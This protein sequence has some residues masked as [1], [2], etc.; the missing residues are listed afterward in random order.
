MVE[1]EAWQLGVVLEGGGSLPGPGRLGDPQLDGMDLLG[2]GRVLLGMRDP[3]ARRHEVQLAG[4]DELLGAQAVEV[5]QLPRQ[6][7]R[8]GL[9]AHVG[10]RPDA[11]GQARLHRDGADMIEEAPGP[12]GA[13]RSLGQDPAHRQ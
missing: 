7:P 8:H 12:D 2:P 1:L 10:M 5:Q 11:E 6:Q 9:E 4:P 13:A 3:V